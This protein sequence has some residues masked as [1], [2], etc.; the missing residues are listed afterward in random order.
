MTS[1]VDWK[2]AGGL[3]KR[4]RHAGMGLV[5]AAVAGGAAQPATAEDVLRALRAKQ[6]NLHPDPLWLAWMRATS[7]LASTP[8]PPPSHA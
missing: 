2:R 7:P 5:V 6:T 3:G 4:L 8:T 1:K